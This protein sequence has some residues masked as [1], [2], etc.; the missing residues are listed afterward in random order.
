M[1]EILRDDIADDAVMNLLSEHLADMYSH[2]PPQSVHA[3]DIEKL[4]H[5]SVTFWVARECGTV[6]GCV[7][8]KELDPIHGEMKSM[9]TAATSRN[10]GVGSR[11][12]EHVIQQAG[13][14]G[15][16]RISLETGSMDFFEP[17]RRLYGKYGF[18]Y[19]GPFADYELDANSVF[20]TRLI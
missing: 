14:R 3:L 9:R 1:I 10:R 13:S 6:L 18:E 17:A 20:M 11:L 7:A 15:Y 4:K 16:T 5:P 8:L 2:S 19:C 12:L